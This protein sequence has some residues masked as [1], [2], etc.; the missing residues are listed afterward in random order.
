M[1]K[2]LK[3]S[4]DALQIMMQAETYFMKSSWRNI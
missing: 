2:H 4:N 3:G 1:K